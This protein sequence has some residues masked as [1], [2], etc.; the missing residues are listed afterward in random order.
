[1]ASEESCKK[2]E[3]VLVVDH[4]IEQTISLLQKWNGDEGATT[5]ELKELR[6]HLSTVSNDVADTIARRIEEEDII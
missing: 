2:A 4:A 6:S 1:M 3:H 5:D